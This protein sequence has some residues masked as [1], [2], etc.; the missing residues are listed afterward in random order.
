MAEKTYYKFKERDLSTD[1]NWS[2]IGADFSTTLKA[3][4][5]RRETE[6]ARLDQIADDY[7]KKTGETPLGDSENLNN[8]G[9]ELGAQ[10]QEFMLMINRQ[11]KN[12]ILKPSDFT[13]MVQRASDGTDTTFAML[14]DWQTNYSK[15]VERVNSTNPDEAA[16]GLEIWLMG[17]MEGFGNFS[18]SRPVL[19]PTNGDIMVG[20]Y[21]KDKNGNLV[22]DADP[23][24]LIGVSNMR[25]GINTFYDKFNTGASVGKFVNGLGK[26]EVLMKTKR[27]TISEYIKMSDPSKMSEAVKS[28]VIT[29]AELDNLTTY[30]KLVNTWIDAEFSNPE[31]IASVLK[32]ALTMVDYDFTF[33]PSD[34]DKTKI[35]VKPMDGRYVPVFEG[36]KG[37]AQKEEAREVLR[38]MA[39]G[40]I[41]KE[42]ETTGSVNTD[43]GWEPEHIGDARKEQKE[44]G[45]TIRQLAV[46]YSGTGG[47]VESAENFLADKLELTSI[48]KT[49]GGVAMTRRD[50]NIINVP[51]GNMSQGE[52]MISLINATKAGDLDLANDIIRKEGYTQRKPSP[53]KSGEVTRTYA[54]EKATIQQQELDYKKA[55]DAKQDVADEKNNYRILADELFKKSP[56]KE[57]I[58]NLL[59][60]LNP[61]IEGG[62]DEFTIT[63]NG[64][65][66]SIDLDNKDVGAFKSFIVSAISKRLPKPY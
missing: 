39:F 7:V 15:H 14:K 5:T 57:D 8:W 10:S 11:L 48:K 59:S 54:E 23:S 53:Y 12:G 34:T 16:A 43:R 37:K 6:R 31:K 47:D 58:A 35:L 9:L 63:I 24:K 40:A 38:L 2:K 29:Q 3:E 26:N 49:A 62:D 52:Y 41:D 65:K 33:D 30:E 45:D 61:V 36:A 1:I 44:F 32:D 66:H 17:Q 51:Y 20:F 13:K 4:A 64:L 46:L 50:G 25:M 22:L 56:T 27:G 21:D 18:N 42:V 55:R 60:G 19:N 28:G